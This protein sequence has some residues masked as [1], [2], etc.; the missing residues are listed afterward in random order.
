MKFHIFSMNPS[1]CGNRTKHEAC[2]ERLQQ[3]LLRAPGAR[4]VLQGRAAL[5]Q[6]DQRR[7]RGKPQFGQSTD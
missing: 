4:L 6:D 7:D 3:A 2:K 5:L 1:I